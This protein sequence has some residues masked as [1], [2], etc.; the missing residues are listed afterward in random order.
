MA[1]MSI[2][3]MLGRDPRLLRLAKS[4]GWSRRET[5][6]CLVLDVWPLCYD[7]EKSDIADI[8]IDIAA[9]MDGFAQLMV[10]SGLAVRVGPGKVRVS[11]AKKRIKYLQAKQASGY[12]GGLK[13]AEARN[14]ES[15]QNSSTG[16]ANSKQPSSKGQA[17]VNPS[18]PDSASASVSPPVLVPD[19]PPVQ[20][21]RASPAATDEPKVNHQPAIRHFEDRYLVAEGG[22]YSWPKGH[23]AAIHRL[24]KL[25]GLDEVI[26]RT[27]LLFDGKGPTWIKPP[28]TVGTL[29]SQWNAITKDSGQTGFGAVL[30]IAN[31]E[32]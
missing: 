4:C 6:G 15:K 21:Q 25:H 26:R 31:G 24:V 2:D 5:A 30:A 18:V 23:A 28:F 13:S 12:K 27:D 16:Q 29:S 19:P 14:K 3:D 1:R 20:D 7:R 32:S 8:D 22:A 17:A 9:D 10:N 11:G